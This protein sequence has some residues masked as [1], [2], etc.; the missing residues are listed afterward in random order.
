VYSLPPEAEVI[1]DR[2][3]GEDDGAYS[4]CPQVS[5]NSS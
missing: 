4:A 3:L 5:S 1:V 2:L